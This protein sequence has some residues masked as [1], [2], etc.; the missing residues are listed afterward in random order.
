MT[1]GWAGPRWIPTMTHAEADSDKFQLHEGE[2][3]APE[4]YCELRR[5]AGL[6]PKSLRAAH[7]GLPRSLYSATVREE[8]RLVAMGRVV[9][10]GL[11]VQ[12][13]DIAVRPDRQGLGLSR[14]VMESIMRFVE[15][16]IDR[17]AVVSLLADVDWL[18]QKFGFE[19]SDRST[20]ML[21]RR[22]P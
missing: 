10:D 12:V 8:G 3:P 2:I 1:V 22:R 14:R 11:H 5:V 9:G 15:R 16:A 4:E 17:S 7:E 18:Y 6:S 19:E 20:A 13:V 21:Y